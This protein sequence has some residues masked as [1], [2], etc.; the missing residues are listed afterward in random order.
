MKIAR[1]TFT[2]T[3]ESFSEGGQFESAIDELREKSDMDIADFKTMLS[4]AYRDK[5]GFAVILLFSVGVSFSSLYSELRL[6]WAP[7][8]RPPLYSGY[9]EMSKGVLS[10]T[11][12]PLK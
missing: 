10:S 3:Y 9:F 11:N 12:S 4:S 2:E 1:T 5:V 7:E 6:V 8:M